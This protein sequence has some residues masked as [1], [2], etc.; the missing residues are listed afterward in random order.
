MQTFLGNDIVQESDWISATTG[1]NRMDEI[2]SDKV[3][4]LFKAL[5]NILLQQRVYYTS[6]FWSERR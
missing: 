4:A 3:A 2:A 1:I 6:R 5:E